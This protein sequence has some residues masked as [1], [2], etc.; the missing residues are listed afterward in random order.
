MLNLNILREIVR[1]SMLLHYDVNNIECRLRYMKINSTITMSSLVGLPHKV[2]FAE[3]CG[4]R[5]EK[6]VNMTQMT[7]TPPS[8][9]L[10]LPEGSSTF[11]NLVYHLTDI[12]SVDPISQV[13]SKQIVSHLVTKHML[14]MNHRKVFHDVDSLNLIQSATFDVAYRSDENMLVCA[15]TGSG[16]TFIALLTILHE[17]RHYKSVE[18]FKKTPYKIVYVAPMKAL[19]GEIV[20]NLGARLKLLDLTVREFTGDMHLRPHEIHDADILVTTPEKWDNVTRRNTG[21]ESLFRL[22]QLLI[23]DEVHLLN[24]DRGPVLEAIVARTFGLRKDNSRLRVVGL[25]A[26]LPN[27][28]EIAEFLHVNPNKGLFYFNWGFRPIPLRLTFIG[29]KN[30][31]F[32]RHWD[33]ED[34]IC[35][36]KLV[37]FVKKGE[38]VLIFVL[39]RSKAMSTATYIEKKADEESDLV[40]FKQDKTSSNYKIGLD[41]LNESNIKLLKR[42]Y[43][44]GVAYHHAGMLRE[45]RIRVEEL[46]RK[47]FIKVLISTTTLAWGVNLPAH[48]VIIKGTRY[49]S[50]SRSCQ[51][52]IDLLETQ[53][54]FGRAGRP[55]Y[56]TLGEAIL[57]TNQINIPY[58]LSMMCWKVPI[59]SHFIESL[60]DH[61]NAEI[62]LKTVTKISEGV[63]WLK[64]TFLYVRMCNQPDYY[65]V[66]KGNVLEKCRKLIIMAIK[67]LITSGMVVYDETNETVQP[68]EIGEVAS[69]T[70]INRATIKI[71]NDLLVEGMT[72]QNLIF[73]L[74]KSKEYE[75]IRVRPAE[76]KELHTLLKAVE[77]EGMPPFISQ[78]MKKIVVL[79][80]SYMNRIEINDVQLY[81]DQIYIVHD[82]KRILRAYYEIAVIKHYAAT[83]QQ[84]TLLQRCLEHKC[85]Q[86]Q[87]LL[88]FKKLGLKV[89]DNSY[90]LLEKVPLSVLRT[91]NM[92]QMENLVANSTLAYRVYKWVKSL[93]FIKE[94]VTCYRMT[95]QVVR[96]HVEV[97]PDF[98]W[99]DGYNNIDLEP[100]VMW[101]VNPSTNQLYSPQRFSIHRRHAERKEVIIVDIN[102]IL[103]ENDPNVPDELILHMESEMWLGIEVDH[104][105]PKDKYRSTGAQY[106]FM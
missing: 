40:Y 18:E 33:I 68:T 49:Y 25:S 92:H 95:P 1:D 28:K 34:R 69:H 103:D 101:V 82:A 79:L 94:S 16:K 41:I 84:I 72:A 73:L 7:I 35:Y 2:I 64:L 54:M 36:N 55:Q 70:Y 53:Q 45:D 86:N 10:D 42:L 3:I 76:T 65:K 21:T 71:I 4:K 39:S 43:D 60:A 9:V 17:L 50:P 12:P 90:K 24:C 89:G 74:T 87:P 66:I 48:A 56:D 38:K 106:A 13:E 27:Y 67:N 83:A 11:D 91:L 30:S 102:V 93:P 23:I 47:G 52:E 100:W 57:I 46:F 5:L 19:A 15:P 88:Q 80:Y 14:D 58:Y 105:I 59:Q 98:D 77:V 78:E 22:V 104:K 51:A 61:L 63:D 26:T 29:S 99:V 20:A 85:W 32:E 44:I 8:I 62:V 96:I 75:Q 31:R 81:L 97:V 6:T 37:E